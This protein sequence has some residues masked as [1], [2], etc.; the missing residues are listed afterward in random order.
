MSAHAAIAPAAETRVRRASAVR[1]VLVSGAYLAILI[2]AAIYPLASPLRDIWR[3]VSPFWT[4]VDSIGP[5][6]WLAVL[7]GGFARQPDGRLWK[8]IFLMMV[9]QHVFT[10]TFVP[11]SIVSSVARVAEQI[12]VGVFVQLLVT[13]PTGYFRGRFDRFVVG[14]AYAL[15]AAWALNELLF[16]G[17][18]WQFLCNPDCVQNVFIVW[19]NDEAYEWLKNVI[20]AG[21]CLVLIPL[22]IVALWR[23]WRVAAPAARRTL[24]PL[25]VGAPLS[26]AVA[27]VEI[28]SR[29]LDFAPGIYFFDSPSGVAIRL[30]APLVLPAGLLLG[31][32]RA[33]WSRGRVA[34]LVVELGRGVPVGGLREVL[35]RALGDTSLQLAFAAPSGSGFVDASKTS[36]WRPRSEP[37]SRRSGR[38][39]RG[40]SRQPMRSGGGSSGT[41]TTGPSSVSSRSRCGSKWPR[42]RHPGHRPCSTRRLASSR[43]PSARSAASPAAST[44]RS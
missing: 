6:L 25:V 16:V 19:P 20:V 29:E 39:G 14:L 22:I 34:N 30:I 21:F 11:N 12:G 23:H 8:L 15:V 36:A 2:A 43:R 1:V 44:R 27:I 42:R 40:S 32:V 33:S 41:S 28:L 5:L 7:L 10:L 35:A 3:P 9:T 24:L 4:A 37:S 18:W 13:F 31:M 38:R 26:L 17:D